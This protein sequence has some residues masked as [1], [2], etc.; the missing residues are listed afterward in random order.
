MNSLKTRL[1]ALSFLEFAVWGCYLVSMGMYLGSVGLGSKIFW[2]YTVQGLVSLIMP[3]L[4]GILADRFIPAQKMLS[5]C[6]LISALAM[7]ACGVY[8]MQAGQAVDFAI[9]FPIY[10]LAVAFYMPTLALSNTAAFTILKENGL[11]TV[12]DFPPIRVFGTVGFIATMWFV[13]CATWH[14]G[15]LGFTIGED[16]TK[17][18]LTHFQF[19]V[20]GVLGVLLCAS[21]SLCHNARL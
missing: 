2:F 12:K 13:N 5:I 21:A 14:D 4:V 10:T 8:C 19:L 9:L 11:D 7:T 17:F 18:Q 6:H 16:S 20:S 1:A 3:G 15:A